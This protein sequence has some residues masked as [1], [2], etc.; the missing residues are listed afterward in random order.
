[1][2]RPKELSLITL[3]KVPA[4]LREL[5]GVIRTRVTVYNWARAGRINAHGQKIK[6]KVYR[7]LGQLYT[8]EEAV[9]N[10]LRELG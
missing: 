5:T 8:T 9:I 3:S 2:P 4:I 6:L 10:F 1:M 7:R